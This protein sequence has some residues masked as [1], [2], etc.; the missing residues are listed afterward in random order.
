ML[1][2]RA[3]WE[4][5]IRSLAERATTSYAASN[6]PM[7]LSGGLANDTITL[8]DAGQRCLVGG[9]ATFFCWRG[10]QRVLDRRLVGK[11]QFSTAA[12]R[13]RILGGGLFG[14]N[15]HFSLAGDGQQDK[16]GGLAPAVTSWS[17]ANGSTSFP[18]TLRRYRHRRFHGPTT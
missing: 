10:M 13:T 16:I 2:S 1:R 15:I 11:T 18:A 7:S 14:I 8:W 17:A 4:E 5:K 3:Q 6:A 12:A 9:W